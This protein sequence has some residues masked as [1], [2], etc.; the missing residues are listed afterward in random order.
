MIFSTSMTYLLQAFASFDKQQTN[1]VTLADFRRVIDI[2]VFKLTD[3]QWQYIKTK[4]QCV[5]KN[6]NYI[7]FLENYT[8]SEQEVNCP[9]K[10]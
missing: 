3:A 7:L 6:V 9:D 10:M 2:F 5:D 4:L 8:M 1:M